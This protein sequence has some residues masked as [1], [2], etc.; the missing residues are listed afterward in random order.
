MQKQRYEFLKKKQENIVIIH[1]WGNLGMASFLIIQA[2]LSLKKLGIE[3]TNVRECL[4]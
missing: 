3:F 1:T 2:R 4:T